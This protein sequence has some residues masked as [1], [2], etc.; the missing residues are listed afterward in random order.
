M[1]MTV[2]EDLAEKVGV[3]PAC[4]NMGIARSTLYYQRSRSNAPLEKPVTRPGPPRALNLQER[5]QVLDVLHCE[6]FVD[7]SP[8]EIWATLL[9]EGTYLCSERTM[10]RILADEKE[11]R[12]RRDQLRHPAYRK[13]ELL[14]EAP[15]QVWSWDITKLKGPV[16]WVYFYLYVILDIY[17]RYVVGWMI[18]HRESAALAQ[19]L[20][21]ESC[22]KQKIEAG[23][24]VIHSDRGSPMIAK[25]TA[26]LLVT[27]GVNK[28]FSRP[29]V[30]DDN[31]Y[32]ESHFK[33]LKYCPDFPERFGSL[34]DALEFCRDFFTWYNRDHHH[35][36][37][38]LMTPEVVHYGRAGEVLE[39]RKKVLEAAF[40]LH[41]ERFVKGKSL[42][43]VVPTAVWINPPDRASIKHA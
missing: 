9:D 42:P 25:T 4:E 17:S 23:Q 43:P 8:A 28:S 29:Y 15:N 30:S 7:K 35:S 19:K 27:L 40:D 1:M 3:M 32:S 22:E 34:Q 26:Q 24:L 12:E 11:V 5:Q 21:R 2:T 13:P 14:A 39:N 41:P 16:K 38:G 33:T 6:R 36:G 10:Y 20:I 31:P 18:A 37:I